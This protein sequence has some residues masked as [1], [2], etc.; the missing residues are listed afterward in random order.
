MPR[1]KLTNPDP[2][3]TPDPEDD[4]PGMNLHYPN[5]FGNQTVM[6][7]TLGNSTAGTETASLPPPPP[8]LPQPLLPSDSAYT[9]DRGRCSG[10]HWRCTN[11]HRQ[12]ISADQP[13]TCTQ[14]HCIEAMHNCNGICIGLH[15]WQCSSTDGQPISSNGQSAK[16]SG[17]C[18]S[19]CGLLISSNGQCSDEDSGGTRQRGK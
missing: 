10:T 11:T 18:A 3:A 14:G 13:C 4:P 15:W 17:Q 2:T 19:T 12:F 7:V 1:A 8:A 6:G 9:S 16:G 5:R